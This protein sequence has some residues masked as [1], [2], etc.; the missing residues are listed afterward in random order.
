M[1]VHVYMLV[2]MYVLRLC[3]FGVALSAE[4]EVGQFRSDRVCRSW[5]E[6]VEKS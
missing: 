2:C 4:T 1:F 6:H 3:T 5:H